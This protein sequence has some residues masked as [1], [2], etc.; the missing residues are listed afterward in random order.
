[1]LLMKLLKEFNVQ[2]SGA[3]FHV[4]NKTLLKVVP[5]IIVLIIYQDHVIDFVSLLSFFLGF[6]EL[7]GL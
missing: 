2:K 1:M 4:A 7:E 6:C 5:E 3:G